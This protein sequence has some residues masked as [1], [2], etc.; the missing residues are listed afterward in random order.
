MEYTIGTGYEVIQVGFPTTNGKAPSKY[1]WETRSGLT[2]TA[3]GNQIFKTVVNNTKQG[4][5]I[6]I[7]SLGLQKGEYFKYTKAYL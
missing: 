7:S 5:A 2:G 4:Y 6:S 1:E 3:T